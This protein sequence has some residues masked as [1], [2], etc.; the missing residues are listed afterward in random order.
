VGLVG[1]IWLGRFVEALLFEVTASDPLTLGAVA[2]ILL[3]VTL[4][5][6]AV[7]AARATRIDPLQALRES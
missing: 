1:A 6:A 5:A 7:P 2:A 4:V 3:A